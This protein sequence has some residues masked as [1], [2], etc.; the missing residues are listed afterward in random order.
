MA[1]VSTRASSTNPISA[2]CSGLS[3]PIGKRVRVSATCA[4]ACATQARNN[5]GRALLGTPRKTG[6]TRTTPP[7]ILTRRGKLTARRRHRTAQNRRSAPQSRGVRFQ[8]RARSREKVS[9][10]AACSNTCAAKRSSSVKKARRRARSPRV[11]L[12]PVA[13]KVSKPE[14]SQVLQDHVGAAR[15]GHDRFRRFARHPNQTARPQARYRRPTRS[16]SLRRGQRLQ[17]R[18]RGLAIRRRGKCRRPHGRNRRGSLS[19][20]L[21]L[22]VHAHPPESELAFRPGIDESEL[23]RALGPSIE[24]GIR[25]AG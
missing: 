9:A 14:L 21:G 7:A 15:Y 4:V 18:Q 11:Y 23:Q 17:A 16:L 20:K 13:M 6:G 22:K 12:R 25:G 8:D 3:D 10:P 19:V 1:K 2:I 5:C 24:I